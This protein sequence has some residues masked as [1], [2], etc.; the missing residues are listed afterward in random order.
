MKNP[1]LRPLLARARLRSLALLA[2][3]SLAAGVALAQTAAPRTLEELKDE[4]QA[5]A[6]RKAYPVAALDAVEV[7]E[8][9]VNLKSLDRDEWAAV[10]SAVGDR[11]AELAKT[12]AATDKRAASRQYREAVEYYLFAR[13]PLENSPGKVRAYEQALAAF[14]DYAKL[15]DPPVEIVRIP[16]NGKQI[17]GYLRVPKNVRP[18]PL[19]ITIGGL[20]GRKENAALRN[21]LY[22][23]YG[24]AYLALDMP[25]TGQSTFAIA[26]PGAEREF[27]AVLDY[28]AQRP[29]LDARR[30]V[31]YGGSWGGHWAARLAYTEKARIRGAVVQGGP[32]HEYF[33]PEWQKKAIGTREYLFELFEA[34]A[35]IYGVSNLED[36]L[37]YGPKMSLV[38]SGLIA[39]PSAPM[40][41]INGLKDTQVPPEDLLL[42]MRS[43]SPKEVWFNPNGGHMGRSAELSDQR[44]FETVTLPWAVRVLRTD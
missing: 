40:L 8:A 13:F 26:A 24:V 32:V 19:V 1:I 38:T 4:V 37:A 29:E 10:W 11:H 21:D 31:V 22:L 28:V 33:Q 9:L 17:V 35:A 12:L 44:I 27:S 36:F 23:A 25:G 16:F 20:D 43:G 2:I 42:L 7:R 18:A 14:A 3:A 5:R 6:E 15:Q 39:Q 41:L 30:V 34:R